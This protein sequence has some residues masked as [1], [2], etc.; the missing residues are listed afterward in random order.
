MTSQERKILRT[1]AAIECLRRSKDKKEGR[2]EGWQW[3]VVV[4][5]AGFSLPL[6]LSAQENEGDPVQGSGL[7]C[8]DL[9]IQASTALPAGQLLGP[10]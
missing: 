10:T 2:R 8:M 6:L 7:N 5:Q 1:T 3:R 9:N 4:V